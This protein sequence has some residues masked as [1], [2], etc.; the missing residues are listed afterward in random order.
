MNTHFPA[1]ASES[2][3]IAILIPGIGIS[4][5]D[6]VRFLKNEPGFERFCRIAGLDKK[7][8]DDHLLDAELVDT[9][10][11]QKL[12]YVV[13]CAMCDLYKHR[14][15]RID[16]VV[17]YSM[18]IYAAM[19]CGGYYEFETGLHILEKAF[20]M[21]NTFCQTT[22]Y[23]YLMALILGLTESEIR[24]LV[25]SGLGEGIDIAVYNGKRGFVV[26]G[27]R[28]K[29]DICLQKAMSS[30][31]L[32]V[33]TIQTHYPYHTLMLNE[34]FL[35]VSQYLSTLSFAVPRY[36]VISPIDGHE[37]VTETAADVI[38][39]ALCT[40]LHFEKVIHTLAVEY[41]VRYCYE[42]SPSKSMRHL[43]R[44]INRHL[45]VGCLSEET[46]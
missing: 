7:Y 45:R 35:P 19:Y 40:P 26:A 3:P 23:D 42:T 32:K 2:S 16:Y 10:N 4:Y 22:P 43:V 13:N 36:K 11:A 37:V 39:K 44:Y 24:G 8:L 46:V 28:E 6:A 33:K 17:G 38:A 5:S 12:S 31:A 1:P 41:H 14:K 21:I 20:E 15:I 29:V 27:I 25:F 9:L 18:G 30:G 34:I